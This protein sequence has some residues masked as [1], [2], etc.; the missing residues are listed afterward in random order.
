MFSRTSA[1]PGDGPGATH[2]G[3]LTS[4][5]LGASWL[6]AAGF[7][8]QALRFQV[9]GTLFVP[10]PASVAL[11]VAGLPILLAIAWR[12]RLHARRRL[13]VPMPR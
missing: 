3:I 2:L 1:T 11:A 13:L 10:E 5:N 8:Q 7:D 6:P 9:N 4:S 12:R